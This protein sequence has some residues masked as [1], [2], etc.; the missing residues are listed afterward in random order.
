MEEEMSDEQ[1]DQE[2][3]EVENPRPGDA[4]T[5]E[6]EMIPEPAKQNGQREAR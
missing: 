2:A 4:E 3:R 6:G 5:P 1:H